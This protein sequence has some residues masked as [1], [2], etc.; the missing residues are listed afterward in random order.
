M[1]N[2]YFEFKQFTIWHDRCAMKVGTDGVLLGAWANIERVEKILDIGTGTGVISLMLTQRN[3]QAII[4]AIEIDE[5]AFLQA[6]RNVLNSKWA[7]RVNVICCDFKKYTSDVK[8]DL[9]VSNPPYF[10]DALRC[11][12]K[13]RSLARH[14]G[15]LNYESLFGYSSKFLSQSGTI[16]III[17]A[18]SEKYIMNIAW[19]HK[20]FPIQKL[21]VYSK[22]GKPCRRIL[23]SFSFQEKKCKEENLYIKL[24]DNQFSNEYSS[25]TR[26]FYLKI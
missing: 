11:P 17:P 15:D 20:L 16:D 7:N 19:R 13:Q 22:V 21:R 9:I 26:D 8:Y 1:S 14:V 5:A 23:F 10:V 3:A 6:K 24:N 2:P 12:N 4:D 18:E 25:L